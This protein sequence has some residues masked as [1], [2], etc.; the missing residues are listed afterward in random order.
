MA[1]KKSIYLTFI[2]LA[3]SP[4]AAQDTIHYGDSLY[5]FNS[6]QGTTTLESA[7]EAN[8][9][10]FDNFP[11]PYYEQNIPPRFAQAYSADS[12]RWIYGVAISLAPFSSSP[13]FSRQQYEELSDSVLAENRCVFATLHSYNIET[14]S[15]S[16]IESVPWECPIVSKTMDYLIDHSVD[17]LYQTVS[18]MPFTSHILVRCVELFFDAPVPVSDTFFVGFHSKNFDTN[19]Y[20]LEDS[21][22]YHKIDKNAYIRV[23]PFVSCCYDTAGNR[24]WIYFPDEN[25]YTTYQRFP[26]ATI[27]TDNYFPW[28]GVYPILYPREDGCTAPVQPWQTGRMATTA[29][30]QWDTIDDEVQ[31]AVGTDYQGLAD[32]M[33]VVATLAAGSAGYTVTGL[34][35]ETWYGAWLRRRCHWITP[36]F[37]TLVWSP[38][39]QV[40]LFSTAAEG[41]VVAEKVGP[42]FTLYPNPTHSSVGIETEALPATLVLYDQQ[43]RE[44]YRTTL[45]ARKTTLGVGDLG[46]GVYHVGLTTADGTAVKRLVVE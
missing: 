2:V 38:W 16:L 17:D 25:D 41:V 20:P 35:P 26:P 9:V 18:P 3:F 39:T 19:F 28:G 33:P 8:Y 44:L 6:P 1:M 43:G 46:R 24:R 7:G 30:L 11:R 12:T 36:T 5:L 40:S 37:D 42:E 34:E 10:S 21:C 13:F 4:A 29:T 27:G 15:I 31:L 23:M 32:T 14:E 22:Y 45:R